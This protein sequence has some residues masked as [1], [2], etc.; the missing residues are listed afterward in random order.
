[1]RRR[2]FINAVAEAAAI[3]PVSVRAQQPEQIRRIGYS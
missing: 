2:D 1:M 3:W